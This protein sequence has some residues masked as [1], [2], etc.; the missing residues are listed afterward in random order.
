MPVRKVSN[1]SKRNTIGDF[2]SIKMKRMIAFESLIERDSIYTFDFEQDV[3]AFEEQPLSIEYEFEGK[4]R[5]YIPDFLLQKPNCSVIVECKPEKFVDTPENSRKFE[6]ARIW[7]QEHG[8]NFQVLTETEL[9]AGFRLENIKLLTRFARRKVGPEARAR[10]YDLLYKPESCI[11]VHAL[12]THVSPTNPT[13]AIPD[14]LCMAY[15]HEI[16][17]P[18][19]EAQVTGDTLV[20]LTH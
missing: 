5:H 9:R 15:H 3:L 6:I 14:I 11:T 10:I 8:Y 13:I 18:L 2:P 19:N 1:R 20:S 7:C 17:V 16:V 4:T 12:A